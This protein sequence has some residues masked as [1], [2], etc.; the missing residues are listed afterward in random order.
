MK[1]QRSATRAR[2]RARPDR[3]TPAVRAQAAPLPD[4]ADQAEARQQ[5][6]VRFGLRNGDHRRGEEA[7]DLSAGKR[8][9]VDVEICRS[10][11]DP[12]HQRGDGV[13]E[14]AADQ[15]YEGGVDR[16]RIG[17]RQRV[18][19]GAGG[20]AERKPHEARYRR[21]DARGAP[22]SGDA[23]VDVRGGCPS[24]QAA[25][26]GLHPQGQRVEIERDRGKA[27]AGRGIPGSL[28]WPRQVCREGHRV[29]V[30]RQRSASAAAA[31]VRAR[32]AHCSTSRDQAGRR[33]IC[34]A[35]RRRSTP[36]LRGG[37]QQGYCNV[38]RLLRH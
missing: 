33:K 32:A 13:C 35:Q 1:P 27:R 28:R 6:Q 37:C 36:H 23:A 7:A 20:H 29:R 31:A 17:E 3:R 8:S 16:A 15:S 25:E 5:K 18:V 38:N 21:R 19:E 4:S 14:R 2:C 9:G 24:E 26:A 34:S 11:V 10:V 30:R 12:G 22:G